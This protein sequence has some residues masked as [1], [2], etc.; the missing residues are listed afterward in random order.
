MGQIRNPKETKKYLEMNKNE[1]TTYKNL[2][3]SDKAVLGRKFIAVNACIK[4]EERC[5]IS[6]LTFYL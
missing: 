1:D 6:D 3:D 4:K 5:Q 2:Q